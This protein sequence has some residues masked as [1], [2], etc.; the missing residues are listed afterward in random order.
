MINGIVI[1]HGK[2][3]GALLN[4]AERILGS[5]EGVY[6]FT[7]EQLSPKGVYEAIVAQLGEQLD[8]PGIIMVDLRGGS[9]WSVAKMLARDYP[10]LRVVTG[11]NLPMLTSFITKRRQK[12]LDEL[13]EL[14]VVDGHRSVLL[15]P[16]TPKDTFEKK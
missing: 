9:C 2:L 12:T 5:S 11:V 13:A 4:A 1:C 3:A 8:H 6:A 15:E 16:G 7:N 10:G 14:L